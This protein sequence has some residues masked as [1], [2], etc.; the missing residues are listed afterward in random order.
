MKIGLELQSTVKNKTGIGWYTQ[1][2]IEH[3]CVDKQFEYEGYLFNF[4]YR[5]KIEYINEQENIAYKTNVFLPYSIYRRIWNYIPLSYNNAFMASADIYHFFN[6]IVPPRVKGRV[7]VT[8]YDMVYKK[9]PETMKP[10]TRIRLEN[11][12]KRSVDRADVVIT[13]SENSKKE[14]VEFLNVD[15][16]KIFIVPPGISL[17][18]FNRYLTSDVETTIRMKYNL[19]EKYILYLGTLEPRKNV[20]TIIKAFALFK[21]HETN[22]KLVLTGNN[23]WKYEGIYK[24]VQDL[25]LEADIVFT[26]YVDENDKWAI[27]KMSELF[28]FPSL[29]E[30]FG[31]PVLEAMACGIPVITSN[32][33]SLPEVVG[34]KGCMVNPYDAEKMSEYMFKIISDKSYRNFLIQYG[35]ERA[36]SFT[37]DI[38]A[39]KMI[40]IYNNMR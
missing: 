40:D 8:V 16:N 15:E 31:M 9:Y 30:G 13:I 29:Y 25:D 26:G 18:E 24:L 33:S 20:E 32:C 4:L 22:I 36:K 14:I 6:Y 11:E 35:L 17:E 12:L 38:S 28:V 37:W 7:V 1:K 21:K 39:K 5:N 34:E 27:Y 10:V 19:P 23:G 3:I 2:L